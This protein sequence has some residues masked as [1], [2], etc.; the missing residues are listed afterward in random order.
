MEHRAGWYV[1]RREAE[2]WI[3]YALTEQRP[4][5]GHYETRAL[6]QNM[7]NQLMRKPTRARVKRGPGTKGL[8]DGDSHKD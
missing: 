7:A 2:G 6:A 3:V 1:P 4:L 5:L 8:F